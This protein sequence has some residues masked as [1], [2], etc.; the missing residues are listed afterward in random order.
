MLVLDGVLSAVNR[1]SLA[2]Q[3]ATVD[4]TVISPLLNATVLTLE[5]LKQETA[6]D[7]EAKV[8]Q[9][10]A[11]TTT[12][13][14]QLSHL[15]PETECEHLPEEPDNDVQL[16]HVHTNEPEQFEIS[17]RQAF[18]LKVITNLQERFLQIEVVE[19]FTI[20]DPSGLLGQEVLALKKLKLLL[21]HYSGNGPLAINKERCID[22]YTELSTFITGHAILKQCKSPQE[23][24]R[25][26]LCRDTLCEFFPSIS[27]LLVHALV[28]PVS[29][30]DC[31][32]CFS[33]M[34]RI[35]TELRNRMNTPPYSY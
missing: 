15:A 10:I 30:T 6:T 1:L 3:R 14:N 25:E 26:F 9:L 5:K 22:E 13:V 24:A 21:D 2:F 11:R 27:K 34:K 29:T 12:E 33:T 18:L 23:F 17:V 19:A 31:E 16:V 8:K 32:R 35:K 20:F 4:L 7:F 28:L